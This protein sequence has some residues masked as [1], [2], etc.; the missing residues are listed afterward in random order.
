MNYNV[1][2][3]KG[4]IHFKNIFDINKVNNYS[5]YIKSIDYEKQIKYNNIS[6]TNQIINGKPMFMSLKKFLL[7]H[8]IY[9]SNKNRDVIQLYAIIFNERLTKPFIQF[10]QPNIPINQRIRSLIFENERPSIYNIN[11]TNLQLLTTL[12][13]NSI[14][15]KI[16]NDYYILSIKYFINKPNSN[17]QEIHCDEPNNQYGEGIICIIPL[18]YNSNGGTTAF[19]N[20]EFVNKYKNIS[21]KQQLYNIGHVDNLSENIKKDFLNAEYKHIF[22]IGDCIL[23]KGDTFHNGTKNKSNYNREFLYIILIKKS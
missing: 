13:N 1:L 4:F 11:I 20:N 12:I 18:N 3:Q 9:I 22:N 8:N 21:N 17:E 7:G 19:Y 23:F 2:N 15:S 6:Y 16:L 5:E 10:N 14:L